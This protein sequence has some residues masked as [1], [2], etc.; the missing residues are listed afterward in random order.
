MDDQ[1]IYADSVSQNHH[2]VLR[3]SHNYNLAL[4]RNYSLELALKEKKVYWKLHPYAQQV[5]LNTINVTLII[6][7]FIF[8]PVR[9]NSVFC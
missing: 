3:K 4:S 9:L 8:T 7:A 2:V 6:D 1:W 5:V